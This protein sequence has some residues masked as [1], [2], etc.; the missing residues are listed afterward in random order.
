MRG[1]KFRVWDNHYNRWEERPCTINKRGNLF[2]YNVDS[3]EWFE[4]QHTAYEVSWFTDFKDK[5]DVE[6]CGGD[7]C[8][9][10]TYSQGAAGDKIYEVQF[11]QYEWMFYSKKTG[12]VISF[13]ETSS[14]F[15]ERIGNIHQ[16][17]LMENPK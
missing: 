4:P 14:R 6:L 8:K 15:V 9:A 7:V 5:N 17:E 13:S 11:S 10:G 3:G 16:P 2:I 12:N 1:L